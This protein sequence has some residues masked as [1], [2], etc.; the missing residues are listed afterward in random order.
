MRAALGG[1]NSAMAAAEIPS[2]GARPALL[3]R[4]PLER[5]QLLLLLLSLF[6]LAVN[7]GWTWLNGATP[8]PVRMAAT[9]ALVFLALW[10]RLAWRRGVPEAGLIVE[11]LALVAVAAGS[12]GPTNSIGLLLVAVAFRSLCRRG[13]A[14]LLPAL[15]YGVA[16]VAGLP[17]SGGV[18]ALG[19]LVLLRVLAIMAFGAVM[20][21][22]AEALVSQEQATEARLQ[23]LAD[24]N[25][26]KDELLDGV[27]HELRTPLSSIL[28]Y[29]ELLLTYDD[30]EV[31]KEFLSIINAESERLCRLVNN[32]LDVA[33]IQSGTTIWAMA[34]V[35]V[36]EL[37]HD[38]ARTH[39]PLVEQQGLHFELAVEPGLP[40]I[41]GDR[42]RLLEVIANLVNNA[43][44]FTVEGSIGLSAGRLGDQVAVSVNDTGIGVPEA[45]R[46]RIFERFEQLRSTVQGKPRGT[47]LGLAICRDVIARHNG[48]IW[49][50]ER[51]GG[52]S[53]FTFSLPAAAAS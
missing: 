16:Y 24:L 6:A 51:P 18:A 49:A 33:K 48:R 26:F 25:R 39:R 45:D 19:P 53:V 35:D 13:R 12:A 37:L 4:R 36:A 14:G 29:S 9:A 50:G 46:E 20:W 3:P 42:D 32:V 44:K 17:I 30:A 43:L 1:D 21:V 47:G 7:L 38:A 8:L 40:A 31:R 28:A 15:T 11:G 23:A 2:A 22:L 52:G 34:P 5:L 41:E 10:W 27:A